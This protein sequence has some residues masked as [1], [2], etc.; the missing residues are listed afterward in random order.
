[1]FYE[2]D[3]TVNINNTSVKFFWQAA[4]KLS[5][6]FPCA[7]S[8]LCSQETC[9]L[10]K[11]PSNGTCLGQ[12]TGGFCDVGCCCCFTSLEIFRSL[13]FDVI[14]HPSVS[15]CWVFTTILYFQPSR[16]FHLNFSGLFR[17]CFTASGTVLSGS[18]LPTSVFYL[19]LLPHTLVRFCDSDADRDTPSRILLCACPHRVV[20]SG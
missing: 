19:A 5:Y 2:S 14:P 9:K 8:F 7:G 6:F 16:R 4:P 20:P 15:Y 1:M 18:F 17:H 3:I 10:N 13:F 12:P 11:T